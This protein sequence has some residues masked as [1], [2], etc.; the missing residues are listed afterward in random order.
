MTTEY[1]A[2]Q[3]QDELRDAV[4]CG[5]RVFYPKDEVTEKVDVT[6][7]YIDTLPD[8]IPDETRACFVDGTVV[9]SAQILNRSIRV[10]RNVVKMGGL[11]AV[12]TDVNHRRGGYSSGVVQDCV[13]YMQA[14]NYDLSVL[15]TGVNSHYARAGWVA[16]PT[17]NMQL[18]LPEQLDSPHDDVSVETGHPNR[19]G[20]ELASIYNQFN[21]TRTG[22]FIKDDEYWYRQSIWWDEDGVSLWVARHNREIVAYLI[23]FPWQIH[24]CGYLPGYENAMTSLFLHFFGEAKA[25]NVNQ[26]HA[27]VPSELRPLLEA[28][29]C[30]ITRR[31]SNAMMIRI[32]HPESL[33]EK[34]VPL[35][36]MRLQNSDFSKW[37]GNIRLVYEA[38]QLGLYI[39]NGQILQ[40]SN[41]NQPAI[42]L[43]VS[44]EQLLKLLLGNIT[45]EQIAFCNQLTLG[46]SEVK[47]LNTLFPKG[48]FFIWSADHF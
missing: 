12:A 41:H 21:A 48:E 6:M 39:K 27:P 5:I 29:G 47:L 32:V 37:E 36:Q 7:R 46:E 15:Y 17:Y 14:S 22:T 44:Q 34:I 1:R 18:T 16:Y 3:N 45:G 8:Y 42:V 2:P 26:V 40:N 31:E 19:D 11:C 20:A 23:A 38:S 4:T 25:Q 43:P 24:E 28:I 30:G 33:M 13:Q 35:F 9:S 10:G